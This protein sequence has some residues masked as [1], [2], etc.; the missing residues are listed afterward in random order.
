[1][2]YRRVLL[3]ALYPVLIVWIMLLVI[4]YLFHADYP[5]ERLAELSVARRGE[6]GWQTF[7]LSCFVTT[8]FMLKVRIAL[9]N[10]M[11]RDWLAITF[12]Y[13]DMG[14]VFFFLFVTWANLWSG[15]RVR[16]PGEYRNIYQILEFN[17]FV[18]GVFFIHFFIKAVVNGRFRM[19]ESRDSTNG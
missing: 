5:H 8:I 16:N 15:W 3:Q 6:I 14:I 18:G 10:R 17:I 12:A 1:M 7:V 19:P 4:G 9:W 11:K 13:L 2:T